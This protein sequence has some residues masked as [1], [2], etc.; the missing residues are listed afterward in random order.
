MTSY[1]Q[2]I[3]CF[4][5]KYLND[6]GYFAP[7]GRLGHSCS[8][9]PEGIPEKFLTRDDFHIAPQPDDNGIQFESDGSKI[10]GDLKILAGLD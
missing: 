10:P 8:A 3:L 1:D 7:D 2:P 6:S 4:F 9:Y 5:C